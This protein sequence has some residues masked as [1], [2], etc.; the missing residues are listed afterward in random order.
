[1]RNKTLQICLTER[2]NN[3]KIA[4]Y[5]QADIELLSIKLLLLQDMGGQLVGVDCDYDA[6]VFLMSTIL[7][8]GAFF[9]S[10]TLKN[11]RSTGY[12]PGKVRN[13]LSDFAVVIAII[14]MSSVNYLSHVNTPNLVIPG[15][16]KPTWEGRDWVVGH[17]LIFVEHL[18]TNPW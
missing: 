13:F 5:V 6:N 12:F 17:A 8:A 14:I 11:F 1:M 4:Y 16:F 10:I 15:S 18:T 3:G 7:F 2:H 9:I